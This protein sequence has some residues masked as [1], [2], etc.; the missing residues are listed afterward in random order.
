MTIFRVDCR[1]SLCYDSHHGR[2]ING[3]NLLNSK[4]V[5]KRFAPGFWL[6]WSIE[7]DTEEIPRIYHANA[8]IS[9]VPKGAVYHQ[10]EAVFYTRLCRDDM[11]GISP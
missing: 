3:G 1:F 8:C 5:A 11:Q 9:S 10:T 6:V 2:E 4:K 7:F